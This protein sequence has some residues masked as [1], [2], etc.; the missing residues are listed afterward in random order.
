MIKVSL[1]KAKMRMD[2]LLERVE[3]GE[4]VVITRGG[5]PVAKLVPLT[6]ASTKPVRKLGSAKG[7]IIIAD[8]F[9][10]PVEDF[11]SV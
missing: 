9:D 3:E 1:G 4:E 8:D 7:K 2:E 10:E 6:E 5:R 11:N